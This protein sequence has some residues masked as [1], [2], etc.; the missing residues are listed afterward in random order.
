MKSEDKGVSYFPSIDSCA[1]MFKDG[2]KDV[3]ID[4]VNEIC[5]LLHERAAKSNLSLHF[6]NIYEGSE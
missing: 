1:C 2:F 5:D 6:S 4:P 3:L